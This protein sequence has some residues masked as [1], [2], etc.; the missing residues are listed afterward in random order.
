MPG[1]LMGARLFGRGPRAETDPQPAE[2]EE[3]AQTDDEEEDTAP[4]A[5]SDPED[6]DEGEV[7][8]EAEGVAARAARGRERARIA[9]ILRSEA[10]NGRGGTALSLALD[11]NL[12]AAQAGQVLQATPAAQEGRLA[13]RM[14]AD[15]NP[16]VGPGG[17]SGKSDDGWSK[18]VAKVNRAA[19]FAR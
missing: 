3:E 4:A 7:P 11:T 14:A 6:D 16:R 19:G 2:P 9:A 17:R 12:T 8:M 18:A 5:E 13:D 10:A 15:A 1:T